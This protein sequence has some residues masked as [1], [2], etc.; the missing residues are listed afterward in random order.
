MKQPLFIAGPC[1]AESI[2]QLSATAQ[3]LQGISFEYFRAGVWKP[4]TRPGSFEGHGESALPWLNEIQSKFGYKVAIEVATSSH[5]EKALKFGMNAIWIGA[6]S[7]TNPFTVQEIS[8][9]LKGVNIPVFVKNPVNPDLKLWLGAME[10]IES[11]T[12]SKIYA[13]HR[14][15]SVYESLRY[16]NE[17]NWQIAL[18]FKI[19]R[20]DIPLIC[21]PSHM[22]GKKNVLL[23]LCQIAMDLHFDGLHL[24]VHHDPKRALTDAEQ[25]ITGLELQR[26]LENLNVRDRNDLNG[27]EIRTLRKEIDHLDQQVIY[28]LAKRMKIADQIGKIKW[29]ENTTIYQADRWKELKEKNIKL[30][31]AYGLSEDVAI[32]LLKLLH[33]EAISIQSSHIY[34]N[35]G[36]EVITD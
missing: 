28:S 7:V 22:G 20:S 2:D 1:S 13:I 4:R 10:R 19:E 24:E 21:D 3:E 34:K 26:L 32:Q 12:N 11:S 14:G 9:S 17:P 27:H 8:D 15:F 6:R 23:E 33:Q 18:D 25:Q 16:R 35:Q 5:V 29:E 31:K 30:A 36:N